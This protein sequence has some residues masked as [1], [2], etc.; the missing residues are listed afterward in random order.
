MTF[1]DT[2]SPQ[3]RRRGRVLACYFGCISEVMVDSSAI[4]IL[5]IA[6]MGGSKSEAMLSTGFSAVFCMLAMIPCAVL[7][8]RIGLKRA[9]AVSCL[10]GSRD[11]C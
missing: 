1:A 4:V 5:Y 11:S 3:E 9:V 10:A 2:L 7:V 6:M 8:G